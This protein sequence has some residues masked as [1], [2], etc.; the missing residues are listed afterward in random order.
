M[1]LREKS[2]YTNDEW[3]IKR[4]HNGV[5][6]EPPTISSSATDTTVA[7]VMQLPA[8]F[9]FCDRD[10]IVQRV[11]TSTAISCGYVSERN[12]IGKSVRN[13][14]KKNTANAIIANDRKIIES[15]QPQ[16]I[17][18]QFTRHD[19][20]DLIATSLKFPWFDQD[21]QIIGIFGCSILSNIPARSL[22]KTL[23]LL[24]KTHLLKS[25]IHESFQLLANSI[26][27][28]FSKQEEHMMLLLIRGKTAKEIAKML[29]LSSR[30]IEHRLE[31]MKIKFNVT[32][33]SAMIEKI[34]D[35]FI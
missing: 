23:S 21:D 30:T 4:C 24:S 22:T 19:D 35:Y 14:A 34:M 11:N 7:D 5:R 20:V 31:K 16:I 25:S 33:K 17:E 26:D 1:P 18:E 29:A 9:Y 12:A 27:N 8:N 15:G 13:I 6:L 32:T 28:H 2:H 10:S 3:L